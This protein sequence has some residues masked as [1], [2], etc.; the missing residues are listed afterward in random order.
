MVKN[1]KR[2]EFKLEVPLDASSIEDIKPDQAVKVVAKDGEGAF[3][4]QTTELDADG[5][6]VATFT[7]YG[8]PGPLRVYVGPA[9]ASDRELEGLQTIQVDVSTRLWGHERQVRLHPIVIPPY[10]WFWWLRWCRTFTIR[11]RVVCPDGSPVPAAE[12]CAYDVDRWFIWSS[13]QEVGCATTDIN[14]AFEI[15]FR[16]CC[17]WWPWWWWRLRVWDRDPI[18]AKRV[19]DVLLRNPDL[20]LSPTP[21]HQPTLAIFNNLL[22]E[23]GLDSRS[24]RACWKSCPL[25]PS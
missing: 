14:G 8:N 22:A 17:G 7:F 2:G 24:A 21:S 12:V 25:P 20:R 9:D 15:K 3:Y 16:W 13:T 18:L 23:E 6:G 19:S 4:S 1:E 10:Y 11:G 5:R